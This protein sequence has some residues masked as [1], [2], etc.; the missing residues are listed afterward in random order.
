MNSLNGSAILLRHAGFNGRSRP[1]KV[2]PARFPALR[3]LRR[4]ESQLSHPRQVVGRHR[5]RE[6]LINFLQASDHHLPDRLDPFAPAEALF[7]A[8]AFAF[9]LAPC[10]TEMP[11][12]PTIDCTTADA[13]RIACYVRRHVVFVIGLHKSTRVVR[14]VC[15][16][17][18]TNVRTRHIAQHV[19]HHFAFRT[20]IRLAG[21]NVHDQTVLVIRQHMARVTRQG[22]RGIALAT[23]AALT[24]ALRFVRFVI[25]R[26][27]A[28]IVRP[29]IIVPT[30]LAPDALAADPRMYQGAVHTEVLAREQAA[31]MCR[32]YRRVE[33]VNH[34][35]E[36]NQSIPVLAKHRVIPRRIF[37]RH[38]DEPTEQKAVR[39]MLDQLPLATTAVQHL[40]QHRPHQLLRRNARPTAF[41][42]RSYIA[43]NL[44]STLDTVAFIQVQNG[45]SGCVCGTNSSNLTV[46]NRDSL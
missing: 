44:G 43:E 18:N 40:K 20:A 39:Y 6:Q 10:A 26:F 9:A 33:Q 4:Y 45:R 2:F 29:T 32:F 28:P 46:L 15:A 27:A 23:E 13:F 41:G 1:A 8:F 37:D 17:R 21:P 16:C 11:S 30:I 36:L 24:V 25:A 5:Q 14:L 42:V 22:W 12:R 7:D 38:T 31:F 35:V 19:R 34:C 3:A